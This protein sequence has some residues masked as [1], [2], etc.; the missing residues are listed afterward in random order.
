MLD[1]LVL[2]DSQNNEAAKLKLDDGNFAAANPHLLQKDLQMFDKH[3]GLPA[4]Q[5][6][7]K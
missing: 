1:K 5:P 4:P 3:S 7:S 6:M 2:Q